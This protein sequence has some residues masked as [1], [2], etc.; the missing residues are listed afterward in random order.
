MPDEWRG[1]HAGGHVD[2]HVVGQPALLAHHHKQPTRHAHAEMGL[3]HPEGQGIRVA[4][5]HGGAAEHHH[6]LFGVLL[7]R[8]KAT[9]AL[10]WGC[11]RRCCLR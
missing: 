9:L 6:Q 8:A 4:Q 2:A 10:A 7:Q 3:E 5:G 11:F 1:T